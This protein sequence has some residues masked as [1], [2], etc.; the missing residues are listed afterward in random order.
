MNGKYGEILTSGNCNERDKDNEG[1]HDLE[2]M[3][4]DDISLAAD[5]KL[6][7]CSEAIKVVIRRRS[8]AHPISAGDEDS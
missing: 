1:L 6:W 5:R 2:K 3:A 8:H 7:E 4:K